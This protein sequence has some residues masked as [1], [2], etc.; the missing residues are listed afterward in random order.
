MFDK[1]SEVE[2]RFDEINALVCTPEVVSDMQKY[3]ALMKELKHLTPVVEKFREYKAV[4]KSIEDCR[5][6]LMTLRLTQTLGQWQGR[7]LNRA[8]SGRKRSA[9][10]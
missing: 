3:T 5:E 1:L 6:M 4:L 10:S 9:R 8:K 7:S 2:K